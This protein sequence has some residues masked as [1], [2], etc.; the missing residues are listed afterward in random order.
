MI[1]FGL[2]EHDPFI[3][4]SSLERGVSAAVVD[5]DLGVPGRL[6]F[7]GVRQ[8]GSLSHL[9][10]EGLVVVIELA[11]IGDLAVGFRLPLEGLFDR[12]Q[13]ALLFRG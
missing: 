12:V 10:S 4:E 5:E 1:A 6:E 7:E 3:G 13:E 11:G 8:A 2:N 9:G